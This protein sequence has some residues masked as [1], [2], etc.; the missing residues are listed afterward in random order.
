MPDMP[1]SSP[2][3]PYAQP[4]A[5]PQHDVAGDVREAGRQPPPWPDAGAQQP[6]TRSGRALWDAAAWA[7][8]T[9]RYDGLYGGREVR[10]DE[11]T[12]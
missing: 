8:E 2:T 6:G 10:R 4:W 11:D 5:N 12:R 7:R 9:G 1:D 3:P